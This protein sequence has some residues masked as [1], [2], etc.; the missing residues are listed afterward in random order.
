M[1]Q[2]RALEFLKKNQPLPDDNAITQEVID[3]YDA[4]RKFFKQYPCNES[5]TLFFGSFG[6][7]DGL[8]VYQLIEDT[9]LAHDSE[10][11]IPELA[12]ALKNGTDSSKYWCA[13]IAVNFPDERLIEGLQT[14]L[15]S[16]NVDIREA[17]ITALECIGGSKVQKL[18]KEQLLLEKDKEVRELIKDVLAS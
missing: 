4:V 10:D 9:I 14:A 1:N 17:T 15:G 11:V 3:D 8:G 7:G 12:V 5:L 6:K 16:D 18:L 2:K 13:Q